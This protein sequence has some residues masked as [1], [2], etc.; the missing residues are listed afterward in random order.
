MAS[1]FKRKRSIAAAAFLLEYTGH[2]EAGVALVEAVA[3][4]AGSLDSM[5]AGRM[6]AST[7]EVGDRVVAVASA[8]GSQ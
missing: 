8:A 4:V 3:E 2:S 5:R 6:G 7:S 1:S